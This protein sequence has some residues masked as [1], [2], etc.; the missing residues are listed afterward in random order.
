MRTT[1]LSFFA[2]AVIAVGLMGSG[3][4]PSIVP[5]A[6]PTANKQ[7][8][9]TLFQLASGAV[10]TGHTGVFD[11]NG[12]LIDGTFAPGGAP[13]YLTVANA[14]VTG[15]TAN[16]LAILTGAPATAVIASAA[17]VQGVVGICNST[18]GTC[19]TTGSAALVVQG[20]QDCVFS[21]ATTAGNYV[22]PDTGTAGNCRDTGSSTA[23]PVSTQGV[24]VIGRVMV[25]NGGAGTNSVMLFGLGITTKYANGIFLSGGTT[26]FTPCNNDNIQGLVANVSVWDFAAQGIL[27]KPGGTACAAPGGALDVQG[28]TTAS[29]LSTNN[30]IT[31]LSQAGPQNGNNSGVSGGAGGLFSATGGA[32]GGFTGGSGS[33]GGA[34]GAATLQAGAGGVA[35]SGSTNGPGGD[36]NLFAGAAGAGAGTAG[37]AG[38]LSV[39]GQPVWSNVTGTTTASVGTLATGSTDIAGKITSATTGAFSTVVTFARTWS[40]APACFVNNETTANIANATSTTAQVTLAGVTVSGDVLSYVC[41]G[42]N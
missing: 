12:N 7:G 11:A 10:T 3:V 19:G 1:V 2:L 34:G 28:G 21:N 33:T 41:M 27:I 32:G 9:S 22:I 36:I 4:T 6:V 18:L 26:G 17:T 37:A 8:N 30:P 20:L 40:R 15:T 35:N 14:G 16:K 31:L 23:L 42:Y 29:A 38:K 25:S 39:K 13:L 5:Q 24:Q